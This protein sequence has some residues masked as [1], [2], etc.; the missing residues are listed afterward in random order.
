VNTRAARTVLT[1]PGNTTRRVNSLMRAS[2]I[3]WARGAI[4][5]TAVV[6]ACALGAAPAAARARCHGS[7]PNFLG[8]AYYRLDVTVY[9]HRNMTCSQAVQLGQRAYSLPHLHVIRTP[10]R[11]EVEGLEARSRSGI[12]LASSPLADRTSGRHT[13]RGAGGPSTSTITGRC[14]PHKPGARSSPVGAVWSFRNG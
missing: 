13:A 12:S 6:A 5:F 7:F 3:C 9:Y 14:C 4:I 2:V 1:A 8:Y 10:P 11:S